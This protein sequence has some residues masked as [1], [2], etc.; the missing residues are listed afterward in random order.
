MCAQGDDGFISFFDGFKWLEV[1]RITP[2]SLHRITL[3]PDGK[4][5]LIS[6]QYGTLLKGNIDDGFKNLKNISINSTF[7][8]AAF[9]QEAIYSFR[10]GTIYMQILSIPSF[11]S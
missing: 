3:C 8:N 10:A 9:Y 5:I 6:G 4:N 1:K 2:S 11:L 7:Y